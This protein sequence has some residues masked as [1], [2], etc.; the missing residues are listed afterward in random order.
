MGKI[1]GYKTKAIK[2]LNTVLIIHRIINILIRI[3]DRIVSSFNSR[4]KVKVLFGFQRV[5]T[6]D[7][8]EENK[9]MKRFVHYHNNVPKKI[10]RGKSLL[11]M[12]QHTQIGNVLFAK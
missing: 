11:K 3:Y 2:M 5:M 7:T 9:K 10:R 8:V 12:E 6:L 1:M 4:R